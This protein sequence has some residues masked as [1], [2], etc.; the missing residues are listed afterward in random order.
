M[1]TDL[2]VIVGR[3]IRAA[4]EAR[5]MTQEQ[6]AEAIGRHIDSVSLI[7]RGRT[8]PALDTLIAISN[9]V[10][11]GLDVLVHPF[12]QVADDETKLVLSELQVRLENLSQ[13]KAKLA[14]EIVKLI[15]EQA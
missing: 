15:A 9:I 11:V 4:R 3:N 14:L 12:D 2:K 5:E 6:F 13:D 10:G 1:K 8:L 7:E